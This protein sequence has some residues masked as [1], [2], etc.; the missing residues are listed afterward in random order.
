MSS[1][2]AGEKRIKRKIF[3]DKLTFVLTAVFLALCVLFSVTMIYQKTYFK[4]K[5]VNGQSMYPTF[6]KDAVTPTGEKKGIGGAGANNGDKNFD[7]VIY[8]N[9][10]Q[11]MNKMERFDIVILRETGTLNKDLIKRI[12]VMPGETFYFGKD[13]DNGTLYIKASN[14]EFAKVD[15]PIGED[16]IKDGLY[17]NYQDPEHPTTLKNN[18]YFVCGDNRGHSSDSRSFG[19]VSFDQIEGLVVAVVG[20]CDATVDNSGAIT[21]KNLKIGW[22]RWIK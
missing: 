11:T 10:E 20:S 6:N 8:D 22:P 17:E 2:S 14:G 13:D 12:I 15:Q 19:P 3:W 9:H 7:C 18:E 1:L 4:L 16:Y 5:W 21:Y